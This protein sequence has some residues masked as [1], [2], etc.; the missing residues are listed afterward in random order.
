MPE[1]LLGLDV[2]S[3]NIKAAFVRQGKKCRIMGAGVVKT[4]EGSVMDGAITYMDAVVECVAAFVA[5]SGLKPSGLAVSINSPDII[6]RN[7]TLPALAPAEIPPAVKFEILK[8]FPT[9]KDTHE[10]T[11]KVLSSDASSVSAL[12]A[13]C[14]LEL[15]NSYRELASRL[16]LPLRR[17]DVRANAQA[18][19][20]DCFCAANAGEET[21]ILIDIGYRNS[22]VGVV[23]K[24]KLV[25][26]RYIMS[27]AAAY[28]NF[29]AGKA[30]ATKDDIEKARLSGDF[31]AIVIDPLDAENVMN[32][33]FMEI[34]D[35]LRQTTEHYASDVSNEKPVYITV[36]GEGSAIPGIE[37]YF[38]GVHSLKPR[39]LIP[40]GGGDT[41]YGELLKNG[42]PKLLLAAA[43]AALT[44]AGDA[45]QEELNFVSA[46][47]SVS[48]GGGGAVA[49]VR[50]R[51]FT[52]FGRLTAAIF[53]AVLIAAAGIVSGLYY[54][55]DRQRSYAEIGQINA[56]I[57]SDAV[58]SEHSGAISQARTK[59][60]ALTAVLDAID[61]KSVDVS[62]LLDDLA[63]KAP[64]SLFITNLNIIDADS[65]VMSGRARD[66]DSVS[67]YALLLR[68][69]DKYDSVRI[70]SINVNQTVAVT[71]SDYGF[72]MTII[73]KAVN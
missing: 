13:L 24:G 26:S 11:Q 14:P 12:A 65:L 63:A 7:L 64:E 19:A 50:G 34:D 57:I 22:L 18:K 36:A 35:Q 20:I 9:I 72:S 2:G 29:T 54:V 8:F 1:V 17:A 30:G 51:R 41:G 55:S 71:H 59:L 40:A 16:D 67:E 39:E 49:G 60:S 25:L 28:D 31:S 10:I 73:L 58:I 21:G 47:D 15:L 43:G 45:D 56:E 23:S 42:N 52:A 3:R 38:A 5:K 69:T 46:A 70:N 48:V 53:A 44:G 68:E 33:C 6:T 62:E 4:P 61:T 66:Y 32:M 37:A 27:G